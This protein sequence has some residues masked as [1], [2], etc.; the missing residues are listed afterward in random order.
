MNHATRR[1]A[2]R[3]AAPSEDRSFV[4]RNVHAEHEPCQQT[5]AQPK[6]QPWASN[7][8]P[9]A[10]RAILDTLGEAVVVVD[11]LGDPVLTNLAYEQLLRD[12]LVTH[13]LFGPGHVQVT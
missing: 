6:A 12:G 11:R 9:D 7:E 3:E 1:C 2:T 5:R 10:L 13:S 8:L 4:K